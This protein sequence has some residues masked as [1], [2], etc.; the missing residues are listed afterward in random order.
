MGDAAQG[1]ATTFLEAA[2]LDQ[3][4]N[5]EGGEVRVHEVVTAFTR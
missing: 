2:K 3:L 1:G 5:A 4:I